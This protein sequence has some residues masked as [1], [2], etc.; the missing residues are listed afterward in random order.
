MWCEP[1]WEL[2]GKRLNCF[3]WLNTASYVLLK[4]SGQIAG[5]IEMPRDFLI[6]DRKGSVTIPSVSMALSILGSVQ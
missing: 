5:L 1:L 6:N 2:A 3:L 4:R